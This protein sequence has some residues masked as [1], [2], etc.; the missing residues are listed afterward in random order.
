MI[1]KLYNFFLI[2][3]KNLVEVTALVFCRIVHSTKTIYPEDI[4]TITP[5]RPLRQSWS[6]GV[7][8]GSHGS[9]SAAS[10][11]RLKIFMITAHAAFTSHIEIY[12]ALKNSE[13]LL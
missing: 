5:R 8:S 3:S 10:P 12:Y 2:Q 9:A 11:K 13:N 1:T 6:L 7:F 4:P